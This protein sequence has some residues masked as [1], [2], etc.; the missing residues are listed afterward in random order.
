[1]IDNLFGWV[2]QLMYLIFGIYPN[3]VDIAMMYAA[4]QQ[5]EEEPEEYYYE[6]DEDWSDE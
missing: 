4:S 2:L 1:M 6:D 5:Q 3:E